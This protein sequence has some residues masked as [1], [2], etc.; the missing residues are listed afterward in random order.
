MFPSVLGDRQLR[1]VGRQ[2]LREQ[3]GMEQ[4]LSGADPLFRG[5]DQELVEQVHSLR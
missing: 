2:R 5:V 3:I 4:G 1:V